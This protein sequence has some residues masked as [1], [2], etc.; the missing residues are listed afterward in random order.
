[1]ASG[2]NR[3]MAEKESRNRTKQNLYIYFLGQQ[4]NLKIE[5]IGARTENTDLIL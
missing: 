4:S 3:P 5:N 2:E 1:V